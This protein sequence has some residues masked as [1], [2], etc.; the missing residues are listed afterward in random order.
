MFSSSHCLVLQQQSSNNLVPA[1]KS[2]C[3]PTLLAAWAECTP[4]NFLDSLNVL[5]GG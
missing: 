2:V 4:S 3:F 1:I 5:Q